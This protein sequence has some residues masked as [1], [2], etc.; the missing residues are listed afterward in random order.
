MH[1]VQGPENSTAQT[2]LAFCGTEVLEIRQATVVDWRRLPAFPF[3]HAEA[4]ETA[5]KD[6]ICRD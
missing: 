4:N 1:Y 6:A 5:G 3:G 2:A